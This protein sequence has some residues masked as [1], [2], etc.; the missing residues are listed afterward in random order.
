MEHQEQITTNSAEHSR[1]HS[2]GR[3]WMLLKRNLMHVGCSVAHVVHR[4][5]S[6]RV[7]NKVQQGH[8]YK[9]QQLSIDTHYM[10][11]TG[12]VGR[13]VGFVTPFIGSR[14]GH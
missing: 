4:L 2:P 3:E 12:L 14:Y 13:T 7:Q 6:P 10:I 5:R 1:R 11:H 8:Q 9:K